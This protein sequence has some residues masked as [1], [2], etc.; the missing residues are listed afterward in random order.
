MTTTTGSKDI[1]MVW[2]DRVLHRRLTE[3]AAEHGWTVQQLI[4]WILHEPEPEEM[5]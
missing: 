4:E 3:M 5:S 2:I 1:R